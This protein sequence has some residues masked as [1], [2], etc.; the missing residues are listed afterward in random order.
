MFEIVQGTPS[1]L[2]MPSSR[3]LSASL[4]LPLPHIAEKLSATRMTILI[5]CGYYG[6]SIENALEVI[7][8]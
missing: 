6:N 1:K 8:S 4:K 5:K 7:K 2:G 3:H